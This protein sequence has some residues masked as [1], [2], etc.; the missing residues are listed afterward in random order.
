M[1]AMQPS[2]KFSKATAH[3]GYVVQVIQCPKDMGNWHLVNDYLKLRKQVFVDRLEW[4]LFHAENLEFEQYDTFD[5]VYVVA[6]FDGEVVGGARLRRTDRVSGKGQVKYSYMIR[7]AC[8]GILPGLPQ[9]LCDD[10]P[11]MDKSIW[12]L[13]RMVVTG[14]KEVSRMILAEINSFLGQE[15]A[16]T[17]LFLGSPAFRRMAS[18]MSWPVKQL[19]PITGNDD[20]RFQ[21]FECPVQE[22]RLPPDQQR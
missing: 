18:S 15:G 13:T 3:A 11:P 8:L 21:V 4:P 16:E 5:T 19:G 6:T 20:G 7:D 22:L 10:L 9:E 1:V 12:E 14:P 17:V 2:H